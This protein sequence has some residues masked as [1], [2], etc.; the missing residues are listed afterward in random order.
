MT[1]ASQREREIER[2]RERETFFLQERERERERERG[3]RE[4]EKEERGERE[5]LFPSREDYLK[6]MS[7]IYTFKDSMQTGRPPKEATSHFMFVSLSNG[8]Q[9]LKERICS[10]GSKFFHLRIDLISKRI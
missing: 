10:S 5:R 4:R 1:C 2:E 7:G 8:D 3:Q 6:S 9:H